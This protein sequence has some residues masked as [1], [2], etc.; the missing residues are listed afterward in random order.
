MQ[1]LVGKIFESKFFG[2]FILLEYKSYLQCTIKF[3]DTGAIVNRVSKQHVITG[4][5]K[6]PL[7]KTVYSV[8]FFGQGKYKSRDK[9]RNKTKAYNTWKDILER[10]YQYQN[11]I[12]NS[13]YENCSVDERWHNFQVFAEWVENNY[14]DY[15]E[16]WHLDKDILVK[17]NRIYSPEACRF[18][19]SEINM[20]ISKIGGKYSG[21]RKDKNTWIARINKL[22]TRVTLGYFKTEQDAIDSYKKAK[23]L[24]IKELA[25]KWKSLIDKEVYRT[26]IEFKL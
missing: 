17:G 8:G 10:C 2:K 7:A 25:N 4:S 19:P 21:V 20:A 5:V 13:S 26:L 3:L 14:K 15:M 22:K 6:D 23:E 16:G 1:E 9:D 18:V 12:R 11:N 24:Y